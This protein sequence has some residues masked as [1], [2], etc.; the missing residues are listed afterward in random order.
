M[1]FLLSVILIAATVAC[2]G[3]NTALLSEA[4]PAAQEPEFLSVGTAQIS[5]P[6]DIAGP[7]DLGMLNL[8]SVGYQQ[9]EYFV[10][11]TATAF[12]NT[13]EL[14]SDGFWQVEPA[15]LAPYTTRVLVRRPIDAAQFNGTVMVEWMNVSAGFDTTPEWDNAHVELLREGYAWVGVT[16]QFVGVEGREGAIVPFHLKGISAERYA[17]TE[18]PGDSFS[19]DIFSQVAQALRAPQNPDLL[20][21]LQAQRLIGAGESQSAFRLTTYVNA[22]HPVHNVYDGYIIHSR[23]DDAT[24]LMQDPLPLIASPPD[25]LIRTDLNV[26]VLTFQTE[27][28]V[29]LP[30]LNSVTVR[31]ADTDRLRFWE[32]TGTAHADRYS[33][34]DGTTDIGDDPSVG[35]VSLLDNIQGFIQCDSP[36]NS[37]PM[38]YVFMTAVRGMN[39]WIIDGTPPPSGELLALSDDMSAFELDSFG[40]VLGGIRTSYVDAPVAILSG[41]GQTGGS[42]CGLFGTTQ[43]FTPA[44][45]VSLYVDEAGY[46]AAVTEATN[47]SVA[48]GFILPVD[49][50]QIIAWAPGQWALSTGL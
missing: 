16:A 17:A 25:V 6:P 29:L 30:S 48:A 13:N 9:T 36:V 43:L 5:L 28:D 8:A 11:G 12:R 2:S 31:Q 33:L 1:K 42:F 23:G 34:S 15:E 10:S 20:D 40:N 35:R 46:T 50:E 26:P 27:T 7:L 21:G 41:L 19:Y 24:P 38:H 49:A 18:H 47:A 3:G 44:E 32:V 39:N 37:G 22:I 14:T 45:M 4:V